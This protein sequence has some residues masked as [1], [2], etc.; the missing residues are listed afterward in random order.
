MAVTGWKLQSLRLKPRL[1]KRSQMFDTITG[2]FTIKATCRSMMSLSCTMIRA[3][4]HKLGQ[5][6]MLMDRIRKCQKV[7]SWQKMREQTS[8]SSRRGLMRWKRGSLRRYFRIL[9]WESK[10]SEEMGTACLGRSQFCCTGLKTILT[11]SGRRPVII[12]KQMKSTLGRLWQCHS[13]NTWT[14]RGGTGLGEMISSFKSSVRCMTVQLKYTAIVT[15][16]SRHSER[17]TT[18][19]KCKF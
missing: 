17:Q 5:S 7:Q 12:W 15:S 18:T 16:L 13:P 11:W 1:C 2:W 8:K 9:A 19:R 10:R 6:Q 3:E 14:L 4:L